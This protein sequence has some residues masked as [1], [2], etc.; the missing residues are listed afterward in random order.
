M[1]MQ[2]HKEHSPFASLFSPACKPGSF[3]AYAG[4]TKCSKCPL[5]SSSHD[6]AATICHCD[7]GF[8]RALKDPTT[9]ACT[10]QQKATKPFVSFLV[11]FI[12]LVSFC[13]LSF[14]SVIESHLNFCSPSLDISE[15]CIDETDKYHAGMK[16]SYTLRAILSHAYMQIF[17][18]TLKQLRFFF[19]VQ[20]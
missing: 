17:E 2:L 4:N 3:K 13:C 1:E 5:H 16:H 7:K 15:R 12:F 8:Y 14:N 9:M 6:Q 10:S 19:I 18:D 11:L 20:V